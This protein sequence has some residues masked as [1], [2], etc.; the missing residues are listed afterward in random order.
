M[1]PEGSF[2]CGSVKEGVSSPVAFSLSSSGN[3]GWVPGQV[4]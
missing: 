3:I 1:S 4:T 2:H